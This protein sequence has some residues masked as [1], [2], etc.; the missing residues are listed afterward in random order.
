[1]MRPGKRSH[2]GA[3]MP[4]DFGLVPDAAQRNP[5]K[6]TSQGAGDG[7][8]QGGFSGARRPDK[9]EDRSLGIG[10]EFA[11][12]QVFDD[13]LFGFFQT[14][15]VLIQHFSRFF[16]VQVVLRALIPGQGGQPIQIGRGHRVFRRGGMHAR[17]AVQFAFGFFLGFFGQV[18]FGDL[19]PVFFDFDIGIVLFPQFFLDGF[20]LFAKKYSRCFLSMSPLTWVWI[21]FPEFENF[22][23]IIDQPVTSF[24]RLFTS[25]IS[26]IFCFSPRD[27]VD[28]G[29]H[30]VGHM[31][32]SLIEFAIGPISLG[33]P[34]ERS[35]TCWNSCSKLAMNAWISL[36]LTSF[37]LMWSTR[38]FR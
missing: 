6:F 30:H 11:D 25:I 34:G 22:Q 17:K 8:S 14:E 13:P 26:R 9:A 23:L 21:L 12:G 20:Q 4:P 33:S 2:I 35:M 27:A 28:G 31:P 10:F 37:S 5:D 29:G 19:G 24:K 7:I 36:S 38:A 32:G 3:A 16:D 18:F 1:M 15:M